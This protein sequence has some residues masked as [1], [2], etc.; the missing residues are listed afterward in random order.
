MDNAPNIFLIEGLDRL[1][2]STL[3]QGIKNKLGYFQDIHF[4]K[5]VLLDCY[6]SENPNRSK[7]LY[8]RDCFENFFMILQAYGSRI[9]C[10]RA[11]LGEYVYSPMYRNYSGEY[12]FDLEA[13]YDMDDRDD[14][15]LILLTEDFS[16]SK[17]FV[18]DGQ[19][20]GTPDKRI[21]EQARFIEAFHKSNILDKRIINVTM[22][23]I[24]SF[25]SKE[26]ILAE[27]LKARDD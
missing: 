21:E 11:H 19:S 9:I 4:S 13:Q 5:P 2:K 20:L 17:H 7:E 12:V 23:G 6:E 15:R 14:I 22:P 26:H 3:V 10:D 16:V 1:G 25:H 8:Q 18:D 24:G 27:A